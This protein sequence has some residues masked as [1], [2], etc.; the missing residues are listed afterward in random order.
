MEKIHIRPLPPDQR[1]RFAEQWHDVQARFV[2]DP[3]GSIAQADTLVNE[4]MQAR[5]YPMGDFESR[6]EDISVDH[7][8]VVRYYRAAH[9]IATR[10]GRGEASTEDLRKAVVYYRDLFDE[11]LGVH[12]H[13][14]T[15]EERR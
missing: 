15:R 14:G 2:D 4:V 13:A 1:E 3:E 11:L 12:A 10:R 9:A 7:P 8:H 5:G 6:A